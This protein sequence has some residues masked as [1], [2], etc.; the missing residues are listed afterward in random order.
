M[1]K[2]SE[3]K[4]NRTA[5]HVACNV[6][7]YPHRP[8]ARQAT[9]RAMPCRTEE[10]LASMSAG[11]RVGATPADASVAERLL[12]RTRKAKTALLAL[13]DLPPIPLKGALIRASNIMLEIMRSGQLA[14]AQTTGSASRPLS[15]LSR[16]IIYIMCKCP[17]ATGAAVRCAAHVRLCLPPLARSSQSRFRCP[18]R[19]RVSAW[20]APASAKTALSCASPRPCHPS[21]LC[22]FGG[23]KSSCTCGQNSTVLEPSR[24]SPTGSPLRSEALTALRAAL[25]GLHVQKAFLGCKQP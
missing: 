15:A 2:Q 10:P 18:A 5:R 11:E 3:T 17:A 13:R 7:R 24:P 16:R 14:Q 8:P 19:P 20:S 6:F 9:R 22:W 25:V 12:L 21:I 23:K 1:R 4:A